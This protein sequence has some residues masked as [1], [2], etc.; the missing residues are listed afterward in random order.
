MF[1]TPTLHSSPSVDFQDRL[2]FE[3][4]SIKSALFKT[5]LKNPKRVVILITKSGKLDHETFKYKG[6][7][8][9]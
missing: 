9:R 2:I 4:V 7:G 3:L 6:R 1:K 8:Q 5:T